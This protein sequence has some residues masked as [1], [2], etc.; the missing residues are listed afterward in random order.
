HLSAIRGGWLA[1]H[2][3]GACHTLVISDVVGD[4]LSVIA[5]SPT[6]PDAS[7]FGDA[8]A[9]VRR[10]GG[11][12]AFPAPVIARLRRGAAGGVP[13]TPKTG[14][15]RLGSASTTTVGSRRA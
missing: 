12:A 5:S 9:V 10:F 15:P 7:T 3:R 1:A 4:D 14:D 2:P 11:E 6:V 8:L 13:E